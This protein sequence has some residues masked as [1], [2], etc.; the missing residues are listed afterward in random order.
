[1]KAIK[2]ALKRKI[3][4][5]VLELSFRNTKKKSHSHHDG[6]IGKL[7]MDF[8]GAC[9]GLVN[10]FIGKDGLHSILKK[11]AKTELGKFQEVLLNHCCSYMR[12][13]RYHTDVL[14]PGCQREIQ[15]MELRA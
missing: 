1:M 14:A 13:R 12:M 7:E 11:K 9:V 2:G 15:E 8:D 6:K 4:W 5:V 3:I 10:I